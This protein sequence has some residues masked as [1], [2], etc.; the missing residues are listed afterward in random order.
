MA[1]T[2]CFE[3]AAGIRTVV[4]S[5]EMSAPVVGEFL[6][7][8]RDYPGLDPEMGVV[9]DLRG[10]AP[11]GPA[12]SG[13]DVR[14]L[15]RDPG[16]MWARL[17]DSRLALVTSRGVD[18]GLAR[19]FSTLMETVAPAR[20]RAFQEMDRARDWVTEDLPR[21]LQYSLPLKI[22]ADPLLLKRERRGWRPNA[23]LKS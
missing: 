17:G 12:L 2:V 16:R 7:A 19:M 4:V 22:S 3:P 23:L 8:L 6:S 10:L 18:F 5:G 1:F 13:L 20:V 9:W 21:P 15:A 11:D 14:A